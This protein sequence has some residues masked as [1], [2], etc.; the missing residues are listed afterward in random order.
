M[1]CFLSLS[2]C[3]LKLMASKTRVLVTSKLE[4]LKRADKILL[5]HNGD[6]FF[7]GTFSELQAQRP[8]FSSLILGLEGYDNIKAE[9]RTSI[10]S[11][12]LRRVSV[13]ESA[14]YRSE[15]PS[16]RPPQPPH[17]PAYMEQ[18]R[19]ERRSSVLL[20]PL[21]AAARKLSF[22]PSSSSMAGDEEVLVRRPAPDRKL[23][24]MPEDEL[25]DESFSG[26]DVYHNHSVHMAG[27]R[28]QSVLDF[29]TNAG[30][31]GRRDPNRSSFRR[32]MS[33][34]P[35]SDLTSEVDIYA[36]RLS[37]D[38]NDANDF[39]FSGDMDGEHIEVKLLVILP[40]DL[41]RFFLLL[42]SMNFN[43]CLSLQACFADQQIEDVFETT[44]WNTYVR[45][46]ST[47]KNLIYVLIFIFI[48]FAAEVSTYFL[49]CV[50][51][52]TV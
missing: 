29:I 1:M 45:Y 6:C 47:N 13:D 28:R 4:H 39:D 10:L 25:V 24:L 3:M 31:A 7:Y 37:E 38:F 36:R 19:E 41:L 52:I 44:K 11:D 34:L 49:Y 51:L 15:R 2:R 50:F 33:I 42:N 26:G 32:K 43:I 22:I 12:T 14:G 30:G 20:N 18:H 23:S 16:F 27:Q 35:Q 40:Y 9:R 48:V 21:A 17:L 46:V 8:D 5:L